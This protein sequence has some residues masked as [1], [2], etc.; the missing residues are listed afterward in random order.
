MNK[1]HT[2]TVLIIAAILTVLF[3]FQ[4]RQYKAFPWDKFWSV[5]GSLF[6]DPQRLARLIAGTALIYATYWLRAM[7]WKIFMR[8]MKQVSMRSVLPAQFI[9]FAGLALLGRPGEF[10]R[11]YLIAKR[12]GLTFASQ[13]GIWLVERF[14]D[15]GAFG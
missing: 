9:G 13:L 10:S 5:S 7:R 11:P 6:H 3:Y 2:L 8:P 15:M 12:H 4:F 1:K 14:F